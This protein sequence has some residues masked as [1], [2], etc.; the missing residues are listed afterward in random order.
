VSHFY[1]PFAETSDPQECDC[2]F[3]QVQYRLGPLGF[4]SLPEL[5]NETGTFGI[6]G[7]LDQQL[8][9]RWIQTNIRA[10]NGDP[11]RVGTVQPS[12]MRHA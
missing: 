8:A 2:V 1:I 9:L 12:N 6:N 3:V 11:D 7:I 5:K 10:F 4:L